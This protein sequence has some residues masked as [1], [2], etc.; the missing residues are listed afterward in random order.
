MS[1]SL[2]GKQRGRVLPTE[3]TAGAKALRH[4]TVELNRGAE[5]SATGLKDEGTSV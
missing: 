5:I 3:P 1:R 2:Q 4:K